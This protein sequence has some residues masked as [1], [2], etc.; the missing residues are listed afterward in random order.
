MLLPSL[1]IIGAFTYYPI[2]KGIMMAFQEYNLMDL[3]N[4]HWIGL[5]N[6]KE[7]FTP[8]PFNSFYN[9]IW[10]TVVWVVVS[11]TFQFLIGFAISLLL[12]KKFFGQGIYKGLIFFPWAVSGFVIGI[13]WRWLFNGT[14]G[15]IND[16]LVRMGI[17]SEPFGFLS[18]AG[19]SI[20]SAIIANIWY[21]IPYFVIM[22]SAALSGVP[23][24]LLEA[25]EVDG[26]SKFQRFFKVTLPFIKPVIVLTL[27]LR[28][29]WIFNFPELI[30]AMTNGGPAGTSRIITS[31]MM[32]KIQA[33]NYGSGAAVGVVVMI[34]LIIFTLLYLA[35]TKFEDMGDEL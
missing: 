21:G 18:T 24:E 4:I 10:N 28:T 13:M 2:G 15:V 12:K 3:S 34:I 31:F 7:L 5:D 29:I 17:L 14:S 26:A 22:I 11:L 8:S 35:L 20:A 27:L 30:Y 19:F 23:D 33:L 1:L 32:E 6:F 16:L 25:A 9:T